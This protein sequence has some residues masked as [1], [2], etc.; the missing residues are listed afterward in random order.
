LSDAVAGS[1]SASAIPATRQLAKRQ[2]TWL[3]SM[4]Q[5]QVIACDHRAAQ[6]QALAGLA[7]LAQRLGR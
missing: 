7:Q 5:R 6:E 2:L 3:R 4:T 1:A